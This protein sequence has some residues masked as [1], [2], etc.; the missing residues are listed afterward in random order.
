MRHVSETAV[1][2]L[3][4]SSLPSRSDALSPQLAIALLIGLRVPSNH[5]FTIKLLRFG[6]VFVLPSCPLLFLTH[7][8]S[9]QNQSQ[10]DAVC[11]ASWSTFFSSIHSSYLCPH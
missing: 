6:L 9:T 3:F 10:R 1:R 2:R 8:T 5:V 11:F 7:C 4:F